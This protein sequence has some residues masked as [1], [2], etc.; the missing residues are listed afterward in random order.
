MRR[1]VHAVAVKNLLLPRYS[2]Y[3]VRRCAVGG[4]DCR[5]IYEATYAE[6]W[7]TGKLTGPTDR[8]TTCKQDADTHAVH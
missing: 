6:A 4:R 1:H 2:S 3:T 8:R 5:Q 7:A